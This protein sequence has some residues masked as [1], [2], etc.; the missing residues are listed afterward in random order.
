MKVLENVIVLL[1]V[2]LIVFF[3]EVRLR[4]FELLFFLERFYFNY[5][6]IEYF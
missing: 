4:L 3:L 6:N 2:I 5:I 1:N